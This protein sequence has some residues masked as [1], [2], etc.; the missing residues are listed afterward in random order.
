[1]FQPTGVPIPSKNSKPPRSP[2]QHSR[3]GRAVCGGGEE[4][5]LY[6]PVVKGVGGWGSGWASKRSRRDFG[7]KLSLK[8][9]KVEHQGE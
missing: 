8:P 1:M 7:P 5:I 6:A 9:Q 3:R 2:D 4:K